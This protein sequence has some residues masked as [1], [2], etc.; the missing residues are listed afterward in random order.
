MLDA[1]PDLPLG[2]AITIELVRHD[3]A[4]DIRKP[5]EPRARAPLPRLPVSPPLHR[6]TEHVA[7]LIH[8]PPEIMTLPTN[9]EASCIQ[10]PHVARSG[11]PT[12]PLIGAG[13]PRLHTPLANP[14][15]GHEDPAGES[16]RFDIAIAQT[17]AAIQPDFRADDLSREAVILVSAG[18]ECAHAI[19]IAHRTGVGQ[20]A[21]EVDNAIFRG[22]RL[23]GGMRRVIEDHPGA[24]VALR[25]PRRLG[26]SPAFNY[27]GFHVPRATWGTKVSSPSGGKSRPR[28]SSAAI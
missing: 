14:F 26:P 27:R 12:T 23:D 5:L 10:V 18:R 25:V 24:G 16:P 22:M 17:E 1:G 6:N 19:S 11:A 20:A 4:R 15:V 21:Q 7:L 9:G 2:R 28:P 13:W 3:H 8:R